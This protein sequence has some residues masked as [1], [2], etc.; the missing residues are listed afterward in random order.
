M[1]CNSDY[2]K[3]SGF[4]NSKWQY[5]DGSGYFNDNVKW[6]PCSMKTIGRCASKPTE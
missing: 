3:Q 4:D 6:K 2:M 5:S 1:P